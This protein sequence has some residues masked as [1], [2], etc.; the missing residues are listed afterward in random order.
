MVMMALVV[1]DSGIGATLAESIALMGPLV[2]LITSPFIGKLGAFVTGSST[3]SNV[4]FGPV[5]LYA[6]HARALNTALV[7]AAQTIGGAIGSGVAPDKALIGRA[8]LA[9]NVREGE[10]MG[11]AL[12]Y[13]LLIV[14][15]I[16][17]E[18]LIVAALIG[19]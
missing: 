11:H 2:Y 5:Q 6:S 16:G 17:L 9:Q 18:T 1:T 14:V 19:S 15:V 12:P 3:N 10:A 13:A 4:M 7:A 8:V